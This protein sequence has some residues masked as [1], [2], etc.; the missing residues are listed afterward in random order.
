MTD[1]TIEEVFI[2]N[3]IFYF[4]P[5]FM[6][7]GV[8]DPTTNAPTP[9]QNAANVISLFSDSYTDEAGTNFFVDWEQTTVVSQLPISGKAT[10]VYNGLNYQGIELK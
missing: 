8:N 5:N 2:D 4:D 9:T 7:L 6:E 10:L 1:A 3:I